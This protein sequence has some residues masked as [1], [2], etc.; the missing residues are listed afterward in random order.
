MAFGAP[1]EYMLGVG[2][3]GTCSGPNRPQ[4]DVE[5]IDLRL[6]FQRACLD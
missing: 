1:T 3:A 2:N 6:R 4:L 5:R